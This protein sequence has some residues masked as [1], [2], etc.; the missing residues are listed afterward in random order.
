[1]HMFSAVVCTVRTYHVESA[2]YDTIYLKYY[3]V[4]ISGYSSLEC[5]PI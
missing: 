2:S 3:M 1:M 5:F 4:F